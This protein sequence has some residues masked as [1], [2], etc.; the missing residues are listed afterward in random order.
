MELDEASTARK[1]LDV[2]ELNIT[3]LIED[4]IDIFVDNEKLFSNCVE[5]MIAS[6]FLKLP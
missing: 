1:M 4:Q 3:F 6:K 5:N 2:G